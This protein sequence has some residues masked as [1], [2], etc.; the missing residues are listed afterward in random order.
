MK[1]V[2]PNLFR[3][4][5]AARSAAGAAAD[6]AAPVVDHESV[7]GKKVNKKSNSKPKDNE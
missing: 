1:K 3:K 2:T 4:R 6:A 7:N 5:A